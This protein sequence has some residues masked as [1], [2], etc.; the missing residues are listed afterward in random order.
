MFH[1]Q[2]ELRADLYQ[3]LMDCIQAGEQDGNAVGKRTILASS[4]IGG[5]RDKIHRYLDAMALMRK[6]GS[7]IVEERLKKVRGNQYED[8]TVTEFKL[9]IGRASCRERVLR[10]V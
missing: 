10:L 9:E 3:G 1:H 8:G 7:T 4:F 5:P 6:G 2:K